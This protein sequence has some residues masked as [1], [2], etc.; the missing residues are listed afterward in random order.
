ME[1]ADQAVT[2]PEDDG[3]ALAGRLCSGRRLIRR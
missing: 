1:S 2:R 3:I